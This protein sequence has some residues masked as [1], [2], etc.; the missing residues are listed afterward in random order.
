M[1]E[2]GDRSDAEDPGQFG[3]DGREHRFRRGAPCHDRRHA[4]P[5][6]LPEGFGGG[7]CQR[8]DRARVEHVLADERQAR[9]VGVV[10]EFVPVP[11]RD[12]DDPAGGSGVQQPPGHLDAVLRA[13]FDIDEGHVG[14]EQRG[15][16]QRL[17]AAG[18]PGHDLQPL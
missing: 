12:Q 7:G 6:A 11:Q 16:T 18:C 5:G 17:G 13:E 9:P 2:Q 3:G 14:P 15:G 4:I 1:A 8:L 10:A